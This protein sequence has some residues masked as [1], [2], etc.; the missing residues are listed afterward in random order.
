MIRMQCTIF[1]ILSVWAVFLALSLPP[2]ADPTY[3]NISTNG[4]QDLLKQLETNTD[5]LYFS[6]LSY[7][8]SSDVKYI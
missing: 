1:L 4:K 6:A 8:K 5:L 2:S 7:Y 3:I